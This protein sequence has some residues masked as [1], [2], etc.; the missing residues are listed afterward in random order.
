M[1]FGVDYEC[2]IDVWSI[3]RLLLIGRPY[4]AASAK[5]DLLDISLSLQENGSDL[6]SRVDIMPQ[7]S[8]KRQRC[9]YNKTNARYVVLAAY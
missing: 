7:R 2:T 4:R 9:K 3:S 8:L 6:D 1:F 5:N